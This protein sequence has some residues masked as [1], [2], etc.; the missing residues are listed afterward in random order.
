MFSDVVDI[1]RLIRG[2]SVTGNI[3]IAQ[4]IGQDDHYIGLLFFFRIA[5]F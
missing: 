4:V 3:T 1:G 2:L 5:A